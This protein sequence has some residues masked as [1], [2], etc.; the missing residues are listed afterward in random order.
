[1]NGYG[2]KIDEDHQAGRKAYARGDHVTARERLHPLAE[3][4]SADAQHIIGVIHA[5]DQDFS[6]ALQWFKKAATQGHVHAQ[7]DLAMSYKEGLGV[8][9]NHKEAIKWFQRAAKQG[10]R[11]ARYELDMNYYQGTEKRKREYQKA[12]IRDDAEDIKRERQT[13]GEFIDKYNHQRAENKPHDQSQMSF[14][15]SVTIT[16]VPAWT[17]L[18][19]CPACI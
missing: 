9:Q 12:A 4:G 3:Q 8:P 7:F 10:H 16:I 2:Q 14:L 1:M 5:N 6:V 19:D 15:F 11:H 17:T 18:C 13:P